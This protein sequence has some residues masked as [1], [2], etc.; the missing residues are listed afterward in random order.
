VKYSTTLILIVLLALVVLQ[1]F[2]SPHPFH[3]TE[4]DVAQ[5]RALGENIAQYGPR[6]RAWVTLHGS[7]W[8]GALD[9]PTAAHRGALCDLVGGYF[10]RRRRRRGR[11]A[12]RGP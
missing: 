11:T 3:P 4:Q 12:H 10:G 8:G 7:A 5:W 2:R 9:T 6:E 1:G